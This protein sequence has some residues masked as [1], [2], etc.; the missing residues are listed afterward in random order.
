M[1]IDIIVVLLT[2]RTLNRFTA[3]IQRSDAKC[4]ITHIPL[5]GTAPLGLIFEDFVHFLETKSNFGQSIL[6]ICPEMFQVPCSKITVLLQW[7][8]LL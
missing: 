1:K 8:T 7:R 5:R 6:W 4:K 2:Q 3:P